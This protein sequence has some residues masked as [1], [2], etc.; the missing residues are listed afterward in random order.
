MGGL[1]LPSASSL[2]LGNDLLLHGF[3]PL[4]GI[5]QGQ[6]GAQGARGA[7]CARVRRLAGKQLLDDGPQSVWETIR[8]LCSLCVEGDLERTSIRLATAGLDDEL[9]EGLVADAQV[10]FQL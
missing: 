2:P 8:Q 6:G 5:R 1:A 3:H 4:P 10:V 9:G 7:G